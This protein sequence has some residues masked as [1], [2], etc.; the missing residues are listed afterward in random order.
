MSLT[1]SCTSTALPLGRLNH[2]SVDTLD[3]L[4][5][6]TCAGVA[7]MSVSPRGQ[8]LLWVGGQHPKSCC[9]KNTKA[10][11]MQSTFRAL[12]GGFETSALSVTNIAL[13]LDKVKTK[14]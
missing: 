5:Q 3:W 11:S 8:V 12:P 14:R 1:C 10:A 7:G 13:S 2:R 6:G 4:I 9:L